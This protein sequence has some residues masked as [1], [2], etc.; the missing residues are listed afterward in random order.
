MLL[1]G[2]GKGLGAGIFQCRETTWDRWCFFIC[3]AFK[4]RFYCKIILLS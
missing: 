2:T 4:I 1:K 3:G